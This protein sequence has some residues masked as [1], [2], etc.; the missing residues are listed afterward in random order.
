MFTID[1]IEYQTDKAVK[2][3]SQGD[4]LQPVKAELVVEI[5]VFVNNKIVVL[6]KLCW[7]R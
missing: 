6:S 1:E 7:R 3:L 5:S 4:I 2:D